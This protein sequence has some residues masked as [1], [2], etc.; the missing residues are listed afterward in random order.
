VY[1]DLPDSLARIR[2]DQLTKDAA[3][4]RALAA[5]RPRHRPLRQ[6]LARVVRAMGY[7]ALSLGDALAQTR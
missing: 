5:A 4:Y 7:F 6:R 1:F 3:A 2:I